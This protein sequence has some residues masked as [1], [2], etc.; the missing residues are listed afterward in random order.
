M[1]KAVLFDALANNCDYFNNETDVNNGYGCNHS[2]QE[3]TEDDENGNEQGCCCCYCCPLG[4]SADEYLLINVGA[5][6]TDEEKKA[7]CNYSN[8]IN[9]YNNQ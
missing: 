7:I 8:Y 9:R 5:D 2:G 3:N 1:R 4:I 6:S